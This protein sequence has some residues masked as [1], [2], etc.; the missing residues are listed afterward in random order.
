MQE[1]RATP[2]KKPA[3]DYFLWDQFGKVLQFIIQYACIDKQE[4]I[5]LH[6][7]DDLM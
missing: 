4:D 5:R 2:A 1:S 3:P 6:E 7:G